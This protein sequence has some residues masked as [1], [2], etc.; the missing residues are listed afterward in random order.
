M[1]NSS[2][3]QLWDNPS[4]PRKPEAGGTPIAMLGVRF[5]A[6]TCEQALEAIDGMIESR[7]PHYLATANVDFLV[8]AQEDEELR[9]ILSDA[10]LVLCDGTPLVWASRWLGNPLPERVAGSDLVPLML[11]RAEQRG[12]RVFILGAEEHIARQAVAN[13]QAKHPSIQIAGQ[14]SPP[15]AP[16]LAMDHERLR[17]QIR[18]A[19]ADI[20][21]VAMGCPKQEKWIA[22]N[23]REIGVPVC[24]GIGATVDFLA[25]AVRRAPV[26]MRHCGLEWTWRLALEP[27][28]LAKRYAKDLWVFGRAMLR[29]WLTLGRVSRSEAPRGELRQPH[30]VTDCSIIEAPERFDAAAVQQS[31]AL[32]DS[33][34]HA[35]S[36]IVDLSHTKFADSTGIG[37]LMRLRK[38]TRDRGS[39]FVLAG[40]R[41][42]VARTLQ[43]MKLGSLFTIAPSLAEARSLLATLTNGSL[44][45]VRSV[46]HRALHLHGELLAE[47]AETLFKAVTSPAPAGESSRGLLLDLK[48]LRFADTA[49]TAVLLRIRELC[50]ARGIHLAL[51]EAS[52]NVAKSIMHTPLADLMLKRSV[53]TSD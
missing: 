13:I 4:Q 32:W 38:L 21:L 16:L 51:A 41:S 43:W 24:V 22:M 17:A 26:W 47:N 28:R 19:K 52:P 20:L 35:G 46:D 33:V 39:Q 18:E 11:E 25:G 23:Y 30:E 2:T 31:R 12:Y 14:V 6:V 8:L 9:R 10:H 34:A 15:F 37:M 36:M 29:Q 50:L 27:K 40:L 49:G 45:L 42:N 44:Q 1:M 53:C 7:E 5:D 48:H 3:L